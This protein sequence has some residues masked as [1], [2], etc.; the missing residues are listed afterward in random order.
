MIMGQ[1]EVSPAEAL[2]RLRA[3]AF[4]HGL[5]AGAVAWSIVERQVVLDDDDTWRRPA[6]EGGRS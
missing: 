1:L 6:A 2:V 3:Y 4:A 5:T